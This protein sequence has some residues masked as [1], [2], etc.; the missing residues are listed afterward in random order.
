MKFT[1]FAQ[2]WMD[3]NIQNRNIRDFVRDVVDLIN[4]YS[5]AGVELSL[6]TGYLFQLIKA[7]N[8]YKEYD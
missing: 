8:E 7:W 2:K 5:L 1:S 3:D 4:A 6:Y